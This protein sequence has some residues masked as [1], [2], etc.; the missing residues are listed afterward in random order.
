MKAKIQFDNILYTS[1]K[2]KILNPLWKQPINPPLHTQHK[3][4][5]YA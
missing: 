2:D 5:E 3:K 4:R 1:Q